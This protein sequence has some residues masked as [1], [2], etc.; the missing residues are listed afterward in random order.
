MAE[1]AVKDLK[2][3][4]T[5]IFDGQEYQVKKLEISN[6]GKFGNRKCRVEL[7]GKPGNKIIIKLADELVEYR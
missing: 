4:D 5:I 2:E 1:K 6:V 7:T 3:G